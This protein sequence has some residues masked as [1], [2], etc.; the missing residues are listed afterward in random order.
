MIC[1]G[2]RLGAR[3]SAAWTLAVTCAAVALVVAAMAALYT[4]LPA[5]ALDTGA[6]QN[7]LTWI[8]DGYTLVLACLVLPGGAIGDRYGR[9]RALTVGLAIF[10]AASIVPVLVDAPA[11][12]IAS[13]AVAGAGAAFVMPATLSLLTGNLP[14][15]KRA[16]AVG[17]W[18][19]IAGSGGVIGM[20]GSGLLL[21]RWSWHSVFVGLTLVALLLLV[22]GFTV[23]DSHDT[24]R[25]QLDVWGMFWVAL[26]IGTSVFA[27]IEAPSRGW[28]DRRVFVMGAIGVIGVVAF[29]VTELRVEH[30]LLDVRLF[31][32][33]GFSSG[34]LSITI[35]FLVTFGVMFL[36][37]QH[38]Q[39]I[40]GFPP[41]HSA[42]ALA[43]MVAPLIVM[44]LVSPT[45]A[46][47]V[48]LRVTTATGL[49]TI[50][51]GLLALLRLDTSSSYLD[52]LWPLLIM[53]AG[54]GMS[55]APATNAIMLDTPLEKHGVSAAV[56]DATREIG[57]A[58]GIA[59][60]GSILSANYTSRITEVLNHLP[61][62]A[63]APVRSSL[64]GA[65]EV[66][67]RAGVTGRPLA[68]Y[69]KTAFW[70]GVENSVFALAVIT[71]AGALFLVP[72]SPGRKGPAGDRS[73]HGIRQ[74]HRYHLRRP[75]RTRA[76]HGDRSKSAS[77]T[78]SITTAERTLP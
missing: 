75:W 29:I 18:A 19:G 66:A 38:F 17:V 71:V 55:A 72:L 50:A 11:G 10:A 63:R 73:F 7:A 37:V 53:S 4:A 78:E 77:I 9:R 35:Q 36:L 34:A 61:E 44:S 39:L 27:V 48:G 14:M 57:A 47:W 13:R 6:D 31:R 2:D 33:R 26:A 60:A 30:P 21:T 65:L 67:E 15:E 45:I 76:T 43:P 8:V 3:R 32:R 52:V 49:L 74:R 51:V 1:F 68:D 16:Y 42:L 22:L 25:P 64:A 24:E 28:T 56:N 54:L 23:P 62:P 58:I 5:I 46:A 12:L 41:L 69:A 20:V 70:G 59:V 40:L